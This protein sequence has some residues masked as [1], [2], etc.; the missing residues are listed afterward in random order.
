MTEIS[1]KAQ[2]L[3]DD[4]TL[5]PWP[6]EDGSWLYFDTI[7][8]RAYPP[9][10]LDAAVRDH[11]WPALVADLLQTRGFWLFVLVGISWS[12]FVW[13]AVGGGHG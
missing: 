1:P 3:I 4:G 9:E 8:G 5:Q 2:R 12:L 11:S 6:K 13:C 7:T 10:R